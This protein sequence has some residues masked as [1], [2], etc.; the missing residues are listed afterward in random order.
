[1]DLYLIHWPV[2]FAG[3]KG[4][5][6][7]DENGDI[8]LDP[9]ASLQA[10][11][12][13]MEKLYSEGRTKAIGVSNFDIPKLQTLIKNAKVK[14]QVNQASKKMMD[15]LCDINVWYVG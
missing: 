7:K 6:P 4:D 13:E 1:M 10:T 15:R 2:A 9:E 11:W 3:N 8:I 12:A 14:P 5:T